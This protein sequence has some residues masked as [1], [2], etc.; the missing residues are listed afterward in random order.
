M[1]WT[2]SPCIA[3][4]VKEQEA[5]ERARKP[6]PDWTF[7]PNLSVDPKIA[8]HIVASPRPE[9]VFNRFKF[10]K[11]QHYDRH[12]FYS[13]APMKYVEKK[14]MVDLADS[15]HAWRTEVEPDEGK[16][17]RGRAYARALFEDAMK[18]NAMKNEKWEELIAPSM[19][20]IQPFLNGST[21]KEG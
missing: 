14:P 4:Q 19:K 15:K 6:D 13:I 8:K 7:K 18:T 21:S 5:R 10:H 3:R 1:P 9:E 17:G 12:L 11:Y 20:K 2:K 16:D